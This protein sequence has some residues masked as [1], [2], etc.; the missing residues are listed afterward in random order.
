MPQE[1]SAALCHL[2]KR[3]RVLRRYEIRAHPVPYDQDHVI[4]FAA[5]GRG[6]EAAG[7]HTEDPTQTLFHAGML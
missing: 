4:G 7:Q 3:R 5:W 1:K 6:G 2:I